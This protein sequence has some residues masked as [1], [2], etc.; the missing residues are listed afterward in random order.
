MAIS[1]AARDF[2]GPHPVDQLGLEGAVERLGHRIVIGIRDRTDRRHDPNVG[3]PCGVTDRSILR[4]RVRLVHG[5]SGVDTAVEQGHLQRVQRQ[6]GTQV[7]AVCQPM[8]LRETR[9]SRK[10]RRRTLP[11]WNIGDV[12]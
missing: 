9:R 8:T 10:R 3:K 6:V 2:H 7:S 1:V 4:T 5:L 11:R 12:R